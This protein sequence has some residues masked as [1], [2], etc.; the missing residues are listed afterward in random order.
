MKLKHLLMI[1]LGMIFAAT[2]IFVYATLQAQPFSSPKT[3][4]GGSWIT[5]FPMNFT[6]SC[7]SQ[8]LNSSNTSS[9]MNA[10]LYHNIGNGGNWTANFTLANGSRQGE[11]NFMGGIINESQTYN[12]TQ[13]GA[14]AENNSGYTWNVQCT[15]NQTGDSGFASEGNVSFKV[16]TI[17]PTVPRIS[18]PTNGSVIG[19][20]NPFINWSQT[21]E[22]NFKRYT[23]QFANDTD[24]DSADIQKQ[25]LI[26]L[27]GTT[28]TS[29]SQ[30]LD[31]NTFYW[32]RIV[33]EDDAG[34]TN[35]EYINVTTTVGVPIVIAVT[36][37]NIY[38]NDNTFTFQANASHPFIEACELYLS[39]TSNATQLNGAS[40]T[41]NVTNRS[42]VNGLHQFT[43][44]TAM[45]DGIYTFGFVCNNTGGNFSTFTIN[46]TITVDTV[47]PAE[48]GCFFP[49]N[50]TKS[51][52][53]TPEFR[54]NEST[55]VNFGNYTLFV[56]ENSD[57]SSPEFVLNF[58][59]QSQTN[60]EVNLRSLNT[61]DRDYFWRVNATDLAGN[62]RISV[63]CSNFFY[64]TD[65]TN[66]L[67]AS[68]WN[69]IAI[70]QAGTIN[71]SD[72]TEGIG[73]NW[74][75]IS[76][77]NSSKQFKN[78]NN[79]SVTNADM[80]FKKGDVVFIDLNAQTFWEN[81]TWDTDTSYTDGGLFNL[82]NSSNQ[83]NIFGMQNQT[84]FTVGQ[85]EL[86]IMLSNRIIGDLVAGG[87]YYYD[88]TNVTFL[89]NNDSI[90]FITPYNNTAIVTRKYIPH[91]FNRS[92]GNNTLLDFGEVAWINI[93]GSINGTSNLMVLN[94]SR[95]GDN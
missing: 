16:D 36:T 23:I 82:T 52:D 88:L 79:G 35:F 4:I 6:F 10:T 91:P 95:M 70:M 60:Q 64:R 84:G 30:A 5:S 69:I 72:L 83:W 56:D 44:A 42:R 68:G 71:A 93:N 11:V 78:F 58:S 73:P 32:M 43:P 75:T 41:V 62:T 63:N 3:P 13:V 47:N 2:A 14:L 15:N 31:D 18:I 1:I 29:F 27:Q 49:A 38:T 12:F 40:W 86:G 45:H 34:N 25:M 37:D 77:Y 19:S 90:Q 21:T 48:F 80:T 51:I 85:I 94:L 67:L 57:F 65:V 66:H 20:L 53:H 76:R 87:E 9:Q 59:L 46:Q 55:D 74:V 89:P 33:A 50:N 8:V 24:F 17:A 61:Q 54:W 7:N 92:F 26:P 81:Q 22:L 28:N 39:N